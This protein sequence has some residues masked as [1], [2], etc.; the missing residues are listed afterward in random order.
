MKTVLTLWVSILVSLI[1]IW[2]ILNFIR[3]RPQSNY[4]RNEADCCERSV[5]KQNVTFQHFY[6]I[7]YIHSYFYPTANE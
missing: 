4:L 5:D 3:E 2:F 1:Y 7:V 6:V